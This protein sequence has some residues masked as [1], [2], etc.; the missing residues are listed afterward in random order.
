M[1]SESKPNREEQI[2]W[3]TLKLT[4][5]LGNRSI[6]R[7]FRRF[8]SPAAALRAPDKELSRVPNLREEALGA[9]RAK[10]TI[11]SPIE[12]WDIL[13]KEGIR[14]LCVNDSDYPSNLAAIADP[15]AVLFARG[16]LEP[17]DLV[18][19]AVVGSRAASPMGAAFTERLCAEL[20]R[21]GVTVV[22]GFALGID[23]A[24]HRGALAG[25]GRTIAV[26]GCGLDIDYP[27]A[28]TELRKHIA[29]SGALV[30]EF[31]LGTTPAP[32]HFPQRN[33]IIS[34]LALGVVVVEAANKSG[35][36]ITAALALEQGREVFAVPGFAGCVR[37]TGPHKLLRQGAKLVESAEDILEEIR[38]LIRPSWASF[39]KTSSPEPDMNEPDAN[40]E[41]KSLLG[42]ID[43]SPR[44]IDELCRSLDWPV[45]RVAAILLTLEL[46]GTVRQLPGKF[47]TLER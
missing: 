19:V 25:Q 13:Q 24:A 11:R 6:L 14:L 42:A 40:E 31:P 10:K 9:L 45:S 43:R 18:S 3:L 5:G 29:A 20:A 33:R 27:H 7:L 35:S 30:S 22:S 38:P 36:L 12:E 44:H 4:P 2:A 21:C 32:G 47:F 37:S 8:G 39:S 41:E 46:K 28:N 23:S 26:L 15:P 34:G 16:A 17:R 1:D